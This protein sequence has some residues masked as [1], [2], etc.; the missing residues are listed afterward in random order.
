VSARDRGFGKNALYSG[1]SWLVP[2]VVAFIAVPITVNGLGLAGYGVIALVGAVSG[3]LGLLD[4]GLGQGIVRYIAMFVS[5][6]QGATARECLRLVLGWFAGVGAVGAFAMWALAPWLA[7]TLLKVPTALV[8]EATAAFRVGGIA[9]ALGMLASVIAYVPESF[10]R[11]DLVSLLNGTLATVSPAG[12]ALLVSLG[13]GILAVVWFNVAMSAV[14]CIAWGAVAVHLLRTLPDEGPAF[15]GVR[16]SFLRFSAAVAANR[17]WT[18]IQ[19]QTSLVVV[20]V[21]GGVAQAGLFQVPNN[22][23]SRITGLLNRMG[24][25]LLPTGS[26]LAAE[27]EHDLL[28]ELYER[29]SRLF[30]LLN[31]S[32]TGAVVVFAEPLLTRWVSPEA[33]A[34]AG[35]AFA[36]LAIAAGVNAVSMAA[37]YLNLALGRPRVNLT[38]S[39]INSFMNLATVYSFT[40]WWGVSGTAASGLFATLNVPVF[41]WYSHRKVL[42]V[43][44]W[45][46]VRRCYA[47]ITIAVGIVLA[48]A[49]VA[50][51]PLAT[52]LGATLGLAALTGLACIVA[53]AAIGAFTPAD[54]ASLRSAFRRGGPGEPTEVPRVG[55]GEDE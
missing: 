17:I 30:Y 33:G 21:A 7:G 20:G 31:A 13:Y 4:L 25:V 23:T 52:S 44:T 45:E 51:R 11:Y 14:S 1:I 5:L 24:T 53:S 19:A 6:K 41:L 29:S 22:I 49:W 43:S 39:L 36:F 46:I 3:Y 28:V 50:L 55:P 47:R 2:A 54:W 38:F 48:L 10:L 18:V 9:F 32:M 16:R 37:G 40:V 12:T 27:G 8:G 42:K 26:Q 15:S 35:V 34:K